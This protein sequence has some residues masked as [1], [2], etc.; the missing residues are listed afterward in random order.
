M[1][2]MKKLLI[3]MA[4]A[5]SCGWLLTSCNK[6]YDCVCTY[7]GVETNRYSVRA[8]NKNAAEDECNEKQ[9]SLGNTYQC[10]IE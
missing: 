2:T 7:N 4:V 5:T 1:K 6:D 3:F 9:S 10:K 8:S